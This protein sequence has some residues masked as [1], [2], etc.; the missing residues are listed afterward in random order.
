MKELEQ[1][2]TVVIK[3]SAIDFNPKNIKKHTPEQIKKQKDNFRAVGV[4]GGIVWNEQTFHLVDGNRRLAALDQIHKYDPNDPDTDYDV[5]VEKVSLDEK[6]EKEQLV[7]MSVANTA[8]D[9]NLIADI[10]TDI[11]YRSAGISDKDFKDIVAIADDYSPIPIDEFVM[12]KRKTVVEV[13][14]EPL[15]NNDDTIATTHVTVPEPVR[16]MSEKELLADA[17]GVETSKE[18]DTEGEEMSAEVK[19]NITK[20]NKEYTQDVAERRNSRLALIG[21]IRFKDEEEK[22]RF[23]EIFEIEDDFNISVDASVILSKMG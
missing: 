8:P 7:F 13:P 10:I 3:R 15:R 23:C 5:K 18:E 6:T 22:A 21:A 9:F 1:S 14:E 20:I 2:Q 17:A 12:P 16:E 4:M 11:D 19:K